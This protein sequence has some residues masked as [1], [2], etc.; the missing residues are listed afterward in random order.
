MGLEPLAGSRVLT[1]QVYDRLVA[2]IADG[3]LRPGQ[4]VRQDEVAAL[5][6]VSRQPVSHA[7]QLVRREG[8]A[9]EHGRKG[10][11]VAPIEPA[12]VR[13][14]YR[15]RGA[16]DALAARLA[17]ERA[18]TRTL[19]ARARADAEAALDAGLGLAAD[20]T[21]GQLIRAD[22]AFHTALYR[23]AA[24]PAIEETVAPQW[25]HFMRSMGAVLLD[26][27]SRPRVWAE[28]G[29]ILRR[30]L[31]GQPEAAAR[32]AFEHAER[33]GREAVARIEAEGTSAA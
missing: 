12:R 6:G 18:G 19:A 3:T 33:A 15:V 8:L 20:A 17:A 32:A 9:V 2:A 27:E 5:L 1:E 11:A 7:L 22:V 14:L 21:A 25:P 30:V 29:E 16:L 24:N 4:R 13:D 23:L 10:L 28:H 31:A 26:P